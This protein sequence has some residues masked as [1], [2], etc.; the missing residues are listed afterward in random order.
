MFD[1][2]KEVGLE[3]FAGD[4]NLANEFV[5]GFAEELLKEAAFPQ[6]AGPDAYKELINGF[7]GSVGKGIGG[8]LVTMGVSG[9]ADLM[10][11][12]QNSILHTKFLQALEKAK[13]S[14]R[15]LQE[16]PTAKLVQYAETIYRFAPHVSTDPNLLSSVLANAIHGEGIDPQTIKSLT[17]LEGRFREN[18]SFTPKAYV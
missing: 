2:V 6:S 12:A 17:D 4:E 8:L 11:G 1:R 9:V 13:Q 3:K 16:V 18:R 14:N 15:I 5:A 7:S 10:R